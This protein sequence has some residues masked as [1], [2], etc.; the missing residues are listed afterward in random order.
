MHIKRDCRSVLRGKGLAR[1]KIGR[2]GRISKAGE[3]FILILLAF[4]RLACV[5]VGLIPLAV[6]S[7]TVE[8]GRTGRAR[9]PSCTII[10]VI[11]SPSREDR[12]FFLR[13]HRASRR[14]DN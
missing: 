8:Q 9:R 1:S 10:V 13:F 11:E 3:M 12:I 4:E 14:D 5:F 7:Y 6:C 2:D